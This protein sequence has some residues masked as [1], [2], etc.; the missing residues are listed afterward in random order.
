MEFVAPFLLAGAGILL[1]GTFG[2]LLY[3]RTGVPDAVWLIGA[4]IVL[5]PVM[6]LVTSA[7]LIPLTPYVAS[8]VL[9]VVLFE[10]GSRLTFSG[11]GATE[12]L[13][14]TLAVGGFLFS[15]LASRPIFQS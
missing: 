11:F 3:R 13:S 5:G 9:V 6:G 14:V 15:V 8:L 10:S 2:D 7:Q 4:G 12:A 1:I